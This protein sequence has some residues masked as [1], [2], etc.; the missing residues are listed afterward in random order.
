MGRWRSMTLRE[1]PHGDPLT[2]TDL[3]NVERWMDRIEFNSRAGSQG[4][5][6]RSSG[7]YPYAFRI[8]RTLVAEVRR[9]QR[10]VWWY[11]RGERPP[12]A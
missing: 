10:Q 12:E 2:D 9:L 8:I 3:Y 6:S 11:E 1:V 5:P 7:S 4:R